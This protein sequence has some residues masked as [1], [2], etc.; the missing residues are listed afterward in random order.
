[1]VK[2]FLDGVAIGFYRGIGEVQKI[3]PF[4]EV[5]FFIGPN[6]AGK[7]IV[8]NFIHEHLPSENKSQQ[9]SLPLNSPLSFRGE[10]EGVF[11]AGFGIR[12]FNVLDSLKQKNAATF[13]NPQSSVYQLVHDTVDRLVCDGILWQQF[14]GNKYVSQVFQPKISEFIN[15]SNA[16]GW[17]K[18]N[19][20]FTGRSGEDI[21][22]KALPRIL[23]KIN[24]GVL[25]GYPPV[26]LVPAKRKLGDKEDEE[27]KDSSGIGLIPKLASL[28][29]PDWQKE[30]ERYV[31][32][33]INTFL[34]AVTGKPDAEIRVPHE[35]NHLLVRMDGKLLPLD[36]LGTGIHEV[37]LIA[38]FCTIRTEQIICI[39]EPEIQLHPTLQRKLIRYLQENTDNQYFIATHSAAFIDTPGASVFRVWNDG[40]QS[41]VE[42]AL[43]KD[44]KWQ[45]C[46]DL[47]YRASDILQANMVIWVEG[48]SD[49]I[50]LNH[51]IA[52]VDPD[53]IEGTHYA[54]MFYGGGLVS[55][56]SAESEGDPLGE[57]IGLRSLNKNMAIVMDSDRDS[58]GA[59]LKSAAQRLIDEVTDERGFV[60]ITKGR[61]IENYVDYDDLQGVLKE[62]HPKVYDGSWDGGEFEHA[63]Y[64]KRKGKAEPYKDANKIG[65]ARKI[66]EQPANLG[67]LDLRERVTELVALIH[68]A[69]GIGDAENEPQI[70]QA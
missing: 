45:I 25:V 26:E 53:L 5:N 56:L 61:E 51:W 36:S 35:R 44:D 21:R 41:Y 23:R 50:Y 37:I 13:E 11:L 1:M 58:A 52:A 9:G 4:S 46:E 27:F 19:H 48:P 16:H 54:I 63:F 2:T 15:I 6:N 18:L 20:S 32:D 31:F 34:Q 7:S 33:A 28:Q 49:R 65:A 8:L 30:Q 43:L 14:R 22:T 66:C 47:G 69:N 38:A 67:V 24:E 29:D 70:L 64:F 40:V 55:H 10:G 62:L 12:K 59:V 60:W 68:R 3:G 17:N 39:E 57:L 42:P